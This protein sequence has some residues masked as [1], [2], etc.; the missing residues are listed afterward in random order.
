MAVQIFDVCVTGLAMIS[1]GT[2]AVGLR[3]W[4][5]TQVRCISP[6]IPVPFN[7]DPHI[8]DLI[9]L[10]GISFRSKFAFCCTFICQVY[11]A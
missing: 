4:I 7:V 2:S 1:H 10:T 6:F 5:R 11:L 8:V 3:R 9:V